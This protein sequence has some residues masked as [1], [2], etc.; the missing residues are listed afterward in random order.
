MFVGHVKCLAI[1]ESSNNGAK[2]FLLIG[3]GKMK[4]VGLLSLH[5]F[6]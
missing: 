4:D 3:C 2:V 1:L 6:I 5:L